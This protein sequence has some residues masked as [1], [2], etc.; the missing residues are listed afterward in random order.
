MIYHCQCALLNAPF[1]CTAERL[2]QLTSFPNCFTYGNFV[3]SPWIAE[4]SLK[5]S[6]RVNDLPQTPQVYG[7]MP[8]WIFIWR[9]KQCLLA[10]RFSHFSQTGCFPFSPA[11]NLK[12][13]QSSYH[14]TKTVNNNMLVV[15][16][17]NKYDTC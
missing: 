11:I 12:G 16:N 14:K 8:S 3:T 9:P 17:L 2:P 7:F 13:V 4:C 5:W 15:V 10:N 1:C 6:L